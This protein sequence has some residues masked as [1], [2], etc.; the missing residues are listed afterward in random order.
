MGIKKT[1]IPLIGALTLGLISVYELGERQG[2]VSQQRLY[3]D[4]LAIQQEIIVELQKWQKDSL[5][6]WMMLE[7]AIM[8]TESRYN[9]NAVGKSKD[10]GVFQ[11]TPIYVKE[12]NRILEKVGV[13]QRY[14]HEDSF[15]IKKSIEMFNIIQNYYNPQH[16]PSVAIQKQN[17][18][19]ESIGY[20]KKVYENLIFIERMET[21]RRE[22]INYHKERH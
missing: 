1:V 6:E 16:S 20:S 18:G 14:T 19:G 8:M 7:M 17:P 22:L 9:P 4:E 13:S 21:A 3:Q 2:K 5:D 12:V 15:N 11:Q 10:Q